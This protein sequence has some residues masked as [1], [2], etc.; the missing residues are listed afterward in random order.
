VGTNIGAIP[1]ERNK[2]AWK[3]FVYR[4]M[5]AGKDGL[6]LFSFRAGKAEQAPS[7]FIGRLLKKLAS[8]A[9]ADESTGGVA[10]GLR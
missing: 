8:K 9:A 1:R 2:Q 10:S 6:G 3:E 7:H 4:S 5:R